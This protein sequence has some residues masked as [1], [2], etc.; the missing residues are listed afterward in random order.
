MG[1]SDM[2][3]NVICYAASAD[4]QAHTFYMDCT[5]NLPA[6]TL[7]GQQLLFVAYAYDPNYIFAIPIKS[8]TTADITTAFTDVYNRL[9]AHGFK[10]AFAIAD[11]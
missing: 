7:K 10:P 4:K 9:N 2:A 6:F 5:G 1:H 8:T 3:A 11:N